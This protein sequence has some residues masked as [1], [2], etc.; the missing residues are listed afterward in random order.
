MRKVQFVAVL[1]TMFLAV[2][3]TALA[4]SLMAY[5]TDHAGD[6]VNAVRS[7]SQTVSVGNRGL[8][9][10]FLARWPEI[11]GMLIGQLVIMAILVFARRLNGE[12]Q[13]K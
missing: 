12:G 5:T 1:W 3:L 11:A 4:L 6:V 10:E 9:V 2:P 7:F 8:G 13:T